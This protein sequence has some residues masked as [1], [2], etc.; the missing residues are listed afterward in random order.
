MCYFMPWHCSWSIV[1]QKN[2]TQLMTD[3]WVIT[4]DKLTWKTMTPIADNGM[5]R[6]APLVLSRTNSL[7]VLY[8][9]QGR[10]IKYSGKGTVPAGLYFSK[11]LGSQ[12]AGQSMRKV[13]VGNG[14]N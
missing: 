6:A 9:M 8:T 7:Q 4:R 14:L 5:K 1:C 3:P 11:E 10:A 12:A 13:V 2:A